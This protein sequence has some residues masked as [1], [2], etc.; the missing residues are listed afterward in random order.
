M[1][2]I[3]K[4]AAKSLY[5]NDHRIIHPRFIK[6]EMFLKQSLKGNKSSNSEEANTASKEPNIEVT[7][8]YIYFNILPIFKAIN[9]EMSTLS[10]LQKLSHRIIV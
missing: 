5:I 6:K 3:I 4:H 1:E 9:T 10:A 2:V 7:P 8:L